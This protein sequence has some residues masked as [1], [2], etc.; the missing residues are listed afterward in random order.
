MKKRRK[1]FTLTASK[2]KMCQSAFGKHLNLQKFDCENFQKRFMMFL[3][4]NP[5]GNS[6]IG[7][8]INARK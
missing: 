5:E 4:S 2:S 1:K 3:T 8:V 7:F 6:L